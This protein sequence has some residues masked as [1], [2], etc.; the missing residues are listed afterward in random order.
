VLHAYSECIAG[1]PHV[2]SSS[3]E[4]TMKLNAIALAVA[5]TAFGPPTPA[6][7]AS[8]EQLWTNTSLGVKLNDRWRLSEE[9]TTRWS[10]NRNG[11]YE[12][13]S[14]T[15][16]GFRVAGG[17]TLWAGYVHSP[18]YS[19]G[20]FTALERRAREQIT[21]DSL[22]RIGKGKLSGRIRLEQRWRDNADG[23]GW[24]ARPQLKYSLPIKGKTALNFSNETFL[25]LNTTT[26]QKQ[27]GLDRTRNLVTISTPITKKLT[28][29]VGYL[30][31]H[32]FV[33]GGEDT[34]DNVAYFGV[35]LSL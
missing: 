27:S 12:V 1:T 4:V 33:R 29:E 25:N 6:A 18:Q 3:K 5:L 35:A 20:N 17:V 11:L 24:R 15:L 31:Q 7:A 32:G 19:G 9:L 10:D 14:S 30:N 34:S 8:D 28:G 16:I 22:A 21:F 26:F 2:L 13:E 23:T